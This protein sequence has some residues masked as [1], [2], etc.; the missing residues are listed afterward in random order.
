ML[1]A[2]VLTCPAD[3]AP[4]PTPTPSRPKRCAQP[5]TMHGRASR[6][7]RAIAGGWASRRDRGSSGRLTAR[8]AP[9]R[10]CGAAGVPSRA[11]NIIVSAGGRGGGLAG[12]RLARVGGARRGAARCR[13]LVRPDRGD[14]VEPAP[15]RATGARPV[16][17]P[18][19]LRT[20]RGDARRAA[21]HRPV[22]PAGRSPAGD[23]RARARPPGRR[24]WRPGTARALD[25]SPSPRKPKRLD[26]SP[27]PGR[28]DP[29]ACLRAR[30]RP[31]GCAHRPRC[32][33][34]SAQLT[35]SRSITKISVLPESW[36][37]PP[38]GPRPSA[39]AR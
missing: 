35:P 36:W 8:S 9:A 11:S 29:L 2:S 10:P 13:R 32:R 34:R 5:G 7:T 16:R 19:P 6:E 4:T 39:G 33:M 24:I 18:D 38:A 27:G 26:R 31:A 22:A 17:L 25:P 15:A 1:G 28:V 30:R 20:A 21:A 3:C 12:L 14:P 23:H 37:P